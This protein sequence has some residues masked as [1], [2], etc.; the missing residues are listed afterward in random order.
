MYT[1]DVIKE[2]WTYTKITV[3]TTAQG[4]SATLEGA[5]RIN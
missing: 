1:G 2:H 4:T 5:K 3:N